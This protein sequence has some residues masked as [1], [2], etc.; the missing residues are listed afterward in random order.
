MRTLLSTLLVLGAC[1][2]QT[3]RSI[4]DPNL[5]GTLSLS[6]QVCDAETMGWLEG[7]VVYTHLISD[8]GELTQTFEAYT[9]SQGQWLIEGLAAGKTYTIYVQYGSTVLDLFDV[10]MEETDMVLE[11]P[12]CAAN[13]ELSV[14]VITG[15]YDQMG[16]VLNTLGIADYDLINGLTGDEL[17]QFLL[18]SNNLMS[19]DA[20][21]FPGGHIEEDI[22]Y[23]TN[24][25]NPDN[26]AAVHAAL[27]Q[28]VE[29]GGMVYASDWSYDVVESIWPDQ[30]DFLG[31]DLVP[32]DAQKGEE[33]EVSASVIDA[34]LQSALGYATVP[35]QFDLDGWPVISS[36][37]AG[38]TVYMQ[39]DVPWREGMTSS[40]TT[41]APLLVGFSSG[42]GQVVFS[43]WLQSSNAEGEA[44]EVIRYML[45]DL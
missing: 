7:A 9:D 22:I 45:Q 31:D 16:D 24:G 13:T 38:V 6:G 4:E 5:V 23:D 8:A 44:L 11:S 40:S 33:A 17:L 39:G 43:S 28:Y 25:S 14:A 15:D 20:I 18:S 19:Y 26:V 29:S 37:G 27:A 1:S 35:V 12:D 36:V 10:T 32:D 41:N 30:I 42:Q 21:F 2:E 3:L 34:G